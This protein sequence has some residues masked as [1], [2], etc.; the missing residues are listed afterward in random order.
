MIETEIVGVP[1]NEEAELK[2]V[3]TCID[4]GDSRLYDEI[5]SVIGVDDFFTLRAKLLYGSIKHLCDNNEPLT[6]VSVMEHLKSVRGVD[7]VGGMAGLLSVM[8][9]TTTELDLKFCAKTV[10]EKSRLRNVIRSCRLAQEQA[11][12]ET[13]QSNDIKSKLEADLEDD[14]IDSDGLT[15]KEA[16]ESISSD[17]DS[18]INGTYVADVITTNIGR[19]DFMLGSGGIASGEV[20]TLSAPTSCGKSALALNIALNCAKRQGKGVGIFSLEMPKKQITK[21]LMQTLSG[22]NYRTIDGTTDGCRRADAF[23]RQGEELDDM[24]IYTSHSVKGADD[25]ASQARSMVKKLGVKLLIIDYLQLIPF[26]TKN[27]SKAEGIA[28]ISHRIKQM[29]LDLDVAIIL[30]A[31]V[32][33][34]GAKRDGGLSLYDLKDSGDI[35]NDADVVLL[36]YPSQG[37]TESSK[38]MDSKG[39]YTELIYKIA[40]NREG[41]RDI[42]CFFKH[43]HCIGRFE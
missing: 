26:D 8:D 38:K 7:E 37:D 31:Q 1:H 32:N 21:R 24:K 27:M 14:K 6:E 34:E 11:E 19:L 23:K 29:A 9:S 30:L 42:G 35:E 41:E 33:R 39:A 5:N 18:I 17:I 28:N 40:K 12:S 4:A 13:V 20:L 16:T 22:I 25:L 2:V 3:A 36:M 10:A 15:L 43:Y